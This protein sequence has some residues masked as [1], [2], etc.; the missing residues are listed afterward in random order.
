MDQ[1]GS[2]DFT[3][4]S[5]KLSKM[6]RSDDPWLFQDDI[7]KNIET[8]NFM[9]SEWITIYEDLDL[10]FEHHYSV[11]MPIPHSK[12]AKS[13]A[14]YT[15]SSEFDW[16]RGKIHAHQKVHFLSRC[17]L[18]RIDLKCLG[19]T[20]IDKKGTT[21]AQLTTSGLG[22]GKIRKIK[23]KT[24]LVREFLESMDQSAVRL[25]RTQRYTERELAEFGEQKIRDLNLRSAGYNYVYEQDILKNGVHMGRERFKTFTLTLGKTVVFRRK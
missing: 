8:C 1:N 24:G 17:F 18:N 19:N 12:M 2:A 3:M 23:I 5:R 10:P 25:Q 21:S 22:I 11:V 7:R 4:A 6:T 20:Y 9:N 13:L 14:N 16:S 15:W